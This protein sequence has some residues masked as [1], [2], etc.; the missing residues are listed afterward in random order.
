[1]YPKE[2]YLIP[3]EIFRMGNSSEPRLSNVRPRDIN[4]ID[5]NG[6]TVIIAN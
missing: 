1:M 6:I 5:I 3:E 4:T 2:F